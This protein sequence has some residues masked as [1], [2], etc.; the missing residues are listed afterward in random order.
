[1]APAVEDAAAGLVNLGTYN[2]PSA[3]ADTLRGS[4]RAIRQ[5]MSRLENTTFLL[6]VQE[7]LVRITDR[8]DEGA[9]PFVI[10]LTSIHEGL[11]S[12]AAATL[13]GIGLQHVKQK[14]LVVEVADRPADAG[15]RRQA[16]SRATGPFTDPASGLQTMV[17]SAD[18]DG[19]GGETGALTPILAG[20]G[21][22]FDFVL[23]IGHPLSHPGFS[24]EP[25]DGSDLVIFALNSADWMAGTVAWLRG[26][27]SPGVLRRSATIIIER[28]PGN[29]ASYDVG[30]PATVKGRRDPAPALG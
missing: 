25:I 30:T 8:L 5:E 26:R 19:A 4:V 28:D 2:L 27:L 20:P 6:S 29:P 21:Q 14:V 22:Q 23:V 11:E 12:S 18:P 1:M 16:A 13:I 15:T 24:P 10:L 9:K 7:L 3:G 17:V